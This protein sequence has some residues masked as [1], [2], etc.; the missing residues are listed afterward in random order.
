MS[1][2]KDIARGIADIDINNEDDEPT[3]G[4]NL[5]YMEQLVSASGS[6]SFLRIS[7][8]VQHS[9]VAGHISIHALIVGVTIRNSDSLLR[10]ACVELLQHLAIYGGW[11][12]RK[13]ATETELR[14]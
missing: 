2:D 14:L 1:K 10:S 8:R 11:S 3:V 12:M 7:R 5:K 9:L 13:W 6:S 4:R